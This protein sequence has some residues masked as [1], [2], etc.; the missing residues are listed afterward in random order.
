M[1]IPLFDVIARWG[2]SEILDGK[3]AA[4]YGGPAI[5]A[6]RD[7][8]RQGVDFG[9]LAPL[10]RYT[11][12]FQ[13]GLIRSALLAYFVSVTEFEL[14]GI[15]RFQL[16]HVMVPP[17]VWGPQSQG[18]IVPFQDY[19]VTTTAAADDARNVQ[20]SPLGYTEPRDPLTLGYWNGHYVL[21]DGYHRAAALWR[22]GPRDGGLPTYKPQI[23]Q[24][25]PQVGRPFVE[26]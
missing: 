1:P 3:Q 8:R 22:Y 25:L 19:I 6:L 7:R 20:A 9:E 23:L 26:D 13:C 4:M 18:R 16:G 24:G 11:L 2:Y 21:L 15:S 17:N 14:G 12:A 5:D 10:E